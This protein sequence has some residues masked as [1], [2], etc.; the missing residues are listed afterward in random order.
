MLERSKP[1]STDFSKITMEREYFTQK[2][3][4]SDPVSLKLDL[5]YPK[6]INSKIVSSAT[7]LNNILNRK[8]T[9]YHL[10]Y[11]GSESTFSIP[12]FYQSMKTTHQHLV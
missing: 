8:I 12:H 9:K 11:R 1:A 2:S 6:T 3:Y 10:V 7:A 4:I 5:T